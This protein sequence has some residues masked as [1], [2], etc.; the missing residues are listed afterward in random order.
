[1]FCATLS[2]LSGFKYR[3]S[4]KSKKPRA[5]QEAAVPIVPQEAPEKPRLS[6]L[7][8]PW[9]K[10]VYV[11]IALLVVTLGAYSNSFRAG[12]SLDNVPLILQDS[13]V[14]A[15]TPENM[16]QILNR[17]AWFM[18]PEKGLYRPLTTFSYLFNYAIVGNQEHPFGYH[19]VN[20]ALHFLNVLLCYGL[21]L[22]VLR[23]FWPSVFIAALWAV[24]P[25]L[26]ESITNIIGRAD[27]L[28]AFG[29]LSGLWM[30]RVSREAMG[31][32]KFAWLF[33]LAIVTAIGIFSKESAIVIV[34]LIALWEFCWEKDGS[35]LRNLGYAITASGLPIVAFLIQRAIVL[36]RSTVPIFP[37]VDNPLLG[38]GF[39][40]ARFAAIKILAK[41]LWVLIWPAKLS[42][43]YYYA[44]IPISRGTLQDWFA[45]IVIAVLIVSVC[46]VFRRNRA[47]FFFA[48]FAFIAMVPTS[49]LL[50]LIGSIMADRFLYV[51]A[52]G[53]AACIVIGTFAL[54]ERFKSR[55]LAPIILCAAI[56]AVGIRTWS[57]NLDWQDN[58]SLL[59]A[60]IR[61]TPNSFA[62][63]F[64]LATNLY[65]S[66]PSHSNLDRVIAE[67]EK[68]LT[69]LDP[70]PDSQ[71]FEDAYANAGTY[72]QL[73][74]DLLV[75][76]GAD[77]KSNPS[78]EA[79]NAYQRALQILLRGAAI[80]KSYDEQIRAKEMARG[81]TDSAIPHVGSKSLYPE[82]AVTYLRLGDTQKAYDAIQRALVVDPEQPKT[83]VTLARILLSEN[84][85]DDA[86]V[87]L[88]ESYMSS[89]D[90]GILGPLAELYRRGL[91]TKGCA[92]SQSADGIALNTFCEPVHNHICRAKAELIRVYTRANRADLI[93]DLKSN[94]ASETSCGDNPQKRIYP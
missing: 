42:W 22:S 69:I 46:K 70:L 60:G 16:S 14:H 55:A 63:H 18:P 20:F 34:P 17:P 78:V 51:P 4:N 27:L 64:G 45:W 88:V 71:N 12:F 1:M 80:G 72:Y 32:R 56:A 65:V 31:A 7:P 43:N 53:F 6:L 41:Y 8:A 35:Q 54:G 85:T 73:K 26:T 59:E 38:A 52:I 75:K 40:A 9:M 92:F 15:A 76:S 84:K 79:A 37:Y 3:M 77:G 30:Y 29:V 24:H 33:V 11:A 66:D 28:A 21:A 36:S 81:R 5:A 90:R 68:S 94:T 23:K 86:A 19:V 2:V 57:R 62:S 10:H 25:V 44:E 93:A 91:D 74:G 47:V 61:D 58:S 82:L 67:A 48:V 83:F 39:F 87:A 50:I 49:N 13:R 89:G